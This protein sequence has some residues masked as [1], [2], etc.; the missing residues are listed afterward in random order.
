MV[1]LVYLTYMVIV[2][3][4]FIFTQQQNTFTGN[5]EKQVLENTLKGYPKPKVFPSK[6]N[7][8]RGVLTF[9]MCIFFSVY[10]IRIIQCGVSGTT[11]EC[12][13]IDGQQT[14]Q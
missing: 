8:F 9:K 3:F 5:A 13:I 10:N 6:F 12:L 14:I 2:L 1:S 4:N 7:T 11:M